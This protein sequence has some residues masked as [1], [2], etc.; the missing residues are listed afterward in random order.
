MSLTSEDLS[1]RMK[2]VDV[3]DVQ[4]YANQNQSLIALASHQFNWEW[5][6]AA[7]PFSYPMPIDFVYQKQSSRLADRFSEAVR[8]K[9]GAHSISREHVAREAIRRKSILRCIAIVA[10]Q[11]PGHGNDKK[12]HAKFLNQDTVFFHG[13]NG[14]AALTQYPVV[15]V[16]IKKVKRGYY[17][18]R[19]P[20]IALPPYSK[21]DES[22]MAQYV[23]HTEQLIRQYPSCWLWSHNRWKDRHL[24]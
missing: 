24:K 18:V 1:E 7:G 2:F 22:V 4:Q 9:F 23:K 14:L 20:V 13:I 12:Y 11:Y 17:E 15:F 3:N 21:Q 10:D 8:S 6:V 19:F 16:N 5:L